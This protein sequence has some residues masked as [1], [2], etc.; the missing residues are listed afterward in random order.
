MM[1]VMRGRLWID[2]LSVHKETRMMMLLEFEK[3]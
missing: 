1:A 3:D 2:E